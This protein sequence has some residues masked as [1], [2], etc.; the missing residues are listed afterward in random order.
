MLNVSI[1]GSYQSRDVFN[2]EYFEDYKENY[3]IDSYFRTT[4]ML[5]IMSDPIKFSY[6]K[7]VKS[8]NKSYFVEY[9]FQEFDKSALKV[10]ESKQPDIIILDFYGDARYGA[11]SYRGEYVVNRSDML[12]DKGIIDL[13]NFGIRYS[14]EK[15]TDDFIVMWKNAFDRFMAF[16]KEKLPNTMLVVNTVKGSNIVSDEFGNTY[17]SPKLAELDVDSINRIWTIFDN[18]AIKKYKLKAIKYDKE[19]TLDANYPFAGA[20]WT[21]VHYHANYWKDFIDRFISLTKG[22]TK[23]EPK[24]VESNLVTDSEYKN[25]LSNWTKKVGKYEMVPYSGYQAIRIKDCHDELGDYRPQVWSR[26]IE[27]KGDGETTYTLSFYIKIPDVSVLESD[28]IIFE[29]RTFKNISEV[30]SAETIEEYPLRICGHDIPDNEEYRYTFT[31]K[32]TGRYLKVAPFMFRCIPGIE[33]SRIKLER[34][35]KVSKYTK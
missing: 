23:S 1:I 9:W 5:S 35:S 2:S 27:I 11:L 4:S 15:N 20:G 17:L 18:Y 19:Y 33:Y 34:S 31:F 10:L 26:P 3:N 25:K 8:E 12:K 7:L 32:P 22:K 13:N 24:D 29:I 30:K 16:M 14:Y 6:Q 28:E 21:L